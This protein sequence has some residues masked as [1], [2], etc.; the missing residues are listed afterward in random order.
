MGVTGGAAVVQRGIE[1]TSGWVLALE[2]IS[3]FSDE[4]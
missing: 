4:F 1:K 2:C 3:W